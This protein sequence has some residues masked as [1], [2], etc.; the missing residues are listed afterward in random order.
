MKD[1]GRIFGW[2]WGE[3]FVSCCATFS[4]R[5]P[6]AASLRPAERHNSPVFDH[7]IR[8]LICQG[9][10][11][12]HLGDLKGPTLFSLVFCCTIDLLINWSTSE[13]NTLLDPTTYLDY[14]DCWIQLV[15]A[16]TM[17]VTRWIQLSTYILNSNWTEG[18]RGKAPLCK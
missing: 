7:S 2:F 16:P 3:C 18:A 17:A 4:Y 8:S 15:T 6:R 14:A 10:D 12:D 9:V 5:N 1:F 13:L 11:V